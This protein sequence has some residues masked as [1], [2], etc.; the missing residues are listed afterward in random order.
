MPWA[1]APL[2]VPSPDG[3]LEEI[4][5]LF[6]QKPFHCVLVSSLQIIFTQ[7]AKE[8]IVGLE[9]DSTVRFLHALR[10]VH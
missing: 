9:F 3:T 8:S 2:P 10:L 1:R 4:K 6:V 5:F 7:Y